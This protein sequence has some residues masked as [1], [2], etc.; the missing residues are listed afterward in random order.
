[1]RRE[2]DLDSGDDG[3]GGA[4]GRRRIG[5]EEEEYKLGWRATTG[6]WLIVSLII[7]LSSVYCC[8]LSF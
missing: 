2:V 4:G 1:M 8:R 6:D 7:K 5:R 3:G